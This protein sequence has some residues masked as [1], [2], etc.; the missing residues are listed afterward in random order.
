MLFTGPVVTRV[1]IAQMLFMKISYTLYHLDWSRNIG[2]PG[3]NLFTPVTKVRLL[4][5]NFHHVLNIV[6]F[7]L[8]NSAASEV[9]DAGEL[10]RKK[11]TK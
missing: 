5:S 4:I 3:R 11:H 10:P 8:G 1:T 7:H 9:S 6:C 2:S